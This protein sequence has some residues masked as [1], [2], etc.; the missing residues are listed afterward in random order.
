[1]DKKVRIGIIG[2]GNNTRTKHIPGFK[3]IPGVEIVSVCNRRPSSSRSVADEYK[4]PKVAKD[5]MDIIRDPEV[6][7]VCIGTWPYL[8][9]DAT[10]EALNAGKHV[11]CEARMG[12]NLTDAQEMAAAARAHPDLVA[13]LVPAPMSLDFDHVIKNTLEREELGD[14]REIVMTHFERSG[15]DG[16]APMHWRQDMDLSG[17]NVS[18]LG[19]F[20]EMLGRWFNKEPEWLLADAEIYTQY[21][22]D[23]ISDKIKEVKVPDSITVLG[24]YE[25]G[26][27]LVINMTSVDGGQPVSEIRI[28]GTEA[29]MRIDFLELYLFYSR[30]GSDY[31][32]PVDI[33]RQ[34]RRGW[35]VE[36]DFIDSIRL[37]RP[38]ELTSFEDGLKYMRFTQRVYNSWSNGGIRT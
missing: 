20:Y 36:Q 9:C 30:L 26:P 33:P 37:G 15:M 31:E 32:I 34:T 4:I 7:A 13:Q 35:K 23:K 27:R 38:V 5:W 1:M 2:A 11:L 16:E 24:R 29:S 25:N 19:I 12:M 8:H 3:E 17:C 28:H 6:D 22:D 18:Y 10:I 14:I 21:R